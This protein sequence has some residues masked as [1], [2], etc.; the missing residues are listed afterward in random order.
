MAEPN[1]IT[2]SAHTLNTQCHATLGTLHLAAEF[3]ITKAW[4]AIFGPSGAGKSSFLR[5]IAGLWKP[6]N[7]SVQLDDNDLTYTPAHQ[8]RIAY[9][10]QQ[11]AL[12]PHMS[13][14][15]NIAFACANQCADSEA[16]IAQ[17]LQLFQLD[18]LATTKP[19]ALS[20]GERQRV[21]LARALASQP[22]FLL[23][24]EVFTGM[25]RTLRDTLHTRLREYCSAHNIA[26]LSVTHDVPEAL[27]HDEVLRIDNGRITAQG[28]PHEVLAEERSALLQQ[29]Q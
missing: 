13:V 9:I 18:S 25:H 1:N 4:T 23:L 7:S 6:Q 12:F 14:R 28:P 10:A 29:L 22:R 27:L 24:D 19:T 11:P 16:S 3:R 8:R 20:G 15:Q 17:M 21:L 5:L 2:P 26:V